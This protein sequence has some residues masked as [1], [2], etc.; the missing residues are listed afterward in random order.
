MKEKAI[1]VVPG[2]K[3][4]NGLGGIWLVETDWYQEVTQNEKAYGTNNGSVA[5]VEDGAYYVMPFT[6]EV[7]ETLRKAGFQEKSISVAISGWQEPAD[8]ELKARW[9]ALKAEQ[10][11]ARNE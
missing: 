6:L 1:Q 2:L 9:E 7:L 3:V 8:Q 10:A 11:A 5:W 4:D